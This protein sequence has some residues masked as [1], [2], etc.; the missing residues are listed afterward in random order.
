MNRKLKNV[1]N[2]I[3]HNLKNSVP[4]LIYFGSSFIPDYLSTKLVMDKF[5][6][7]TGQA[8]EG[9]KNLV[10]RELVEKFGMDNA[11]VV[12]SAAYNTIGIIGTYAASKA[13]DLAFNNF[14]TIKPS[15]R[16][17]L[18]YKTPKIFKG[19][20][21]FIGTSK[22]LATVNNLF[23]YFL[24]DSPSNLFHHWNNFVYNLVPQAKVP[25]SLSVLLYTLPLTVT[26]LGITYLLL[27]EKSPDN[28]DLNSLSRIKKKM[29]RDNY[30]SKNDRRVLSS[31]FNEEIKTFKGH[32][33][34]VYKTDLI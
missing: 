23:N 30:L 33:G 9:E 32:Y 21:T 6:Q 16:G 24:G 27:R 14:Y 22:Y 15:Q 19:L 3:G 2:D 8:L 5:S 11:F 28:L 4:H 12:H 17:R 10:F 25:E 13:L 1:L 34:H 20:L 26:S 31:L 7:F 18:I 29:K